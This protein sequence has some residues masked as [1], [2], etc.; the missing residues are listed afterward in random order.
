MSRTDAMLNQQLGPRGA[1]SGSHHQH[2]TR[3]HRNL[4]EQTTCIVS[5]QLE[6]YDATPRREVKVCAEKNGRKL[7]LCVFDEDVQRTRT[8]ALLVSCTSHTHPAG[9]VNDCHCDEGI[10]KYVHRARVPGSHS[11]HVWSEGSQYETSLVNNA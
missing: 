5:Y 1:S 7:N 4:R 6:A 11:A 3:L 9:R 2:N 8:N 10:E